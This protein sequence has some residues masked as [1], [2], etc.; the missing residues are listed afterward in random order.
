MCVLNNVNNSN[1]K[2]IDT[3]FLRAQERS[4]EKMNSDSIKDMPILFQCTSNDTKNVWRKF[5]KGF[6][7]VKIH[8]YLTDYERASF[9][10]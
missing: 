4:A 8:V 10:R 5:L 6:L 2:K 9:H 7:P 1:H 3:Y